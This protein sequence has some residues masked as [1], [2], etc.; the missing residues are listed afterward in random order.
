[1]IW[2]CP[3]AI[4]S[5]WRTMLTHSFQLT[6]IIWEWSYPPEKHTEFLGQSI[7]HSR[8]KIFHCCWTLSL[9][10]LLQNCTEESSLGRKEDP[11][12]TEC[13]SN[14]YHRN[15]MIFCLVYELKFQVFSWGGC[16]KAL[17]RCVLARGLGL[18]RCL[19]SF[20]FPCLRLNIAREG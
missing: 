3:I 18:G 10:C 13:N 19:A 5:G 14:A 16:S 4:I 12:M 15:E 1:M 2:P 6:K 17:W 9:H 11:F 7:S 8:S 20:E